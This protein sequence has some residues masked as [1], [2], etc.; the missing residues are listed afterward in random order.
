MVCLVFVERHHDAVVANRDL[1]VDDRVAVDRFEHVHPLAGRL[2]AEL[3]GFTTYNV[4]RTAIFVNKLQQ[5]CSG[6]NHV[7]EMSACRLI[8]APPWADRAGFVEQRFEPLAIGAMTASQSGRP[9]RLRARR[10]S[11]RRHASA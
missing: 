8:G 2:V 6:S 1:H 9:D 7:S 11:A 10:T 5:P 3:A 4:V